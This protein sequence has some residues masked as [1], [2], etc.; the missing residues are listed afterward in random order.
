MWRDG[1][2]EAEEVHTLDIGMY[3]PNELRM[4]LERAGFKDIVVH[5]EHTE[6]EPTSEDDFLVFVA[7]K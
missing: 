7:K 1:T 4:M 5:G 6:A 3:F 2:L